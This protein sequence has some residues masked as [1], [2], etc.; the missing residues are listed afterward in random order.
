MWAIL[1]HAAYNW[2]KKILSCC[3]LYCALLNLFLCSMWT[4][5]CG[6]ELFCWIFVSLAL[7]FQYGQDEPEYCQVWASVRFFESWGCWCRFRLGVLSK[8]LHLSLGKNRKKNSTQPCLHNINITEYIGDTCQ[9][10]RLVLRDSLVRECVSRF[11]WPNAVG[12]C[13]L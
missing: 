7:C 2:C 6:Q 12:E 10:S 8:D 11:V 3:W 9:W 4:L 5:V 1:P 13:D